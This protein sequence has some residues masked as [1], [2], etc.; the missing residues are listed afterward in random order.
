[1]GSKDSDELL[2]V[3]CFNLVVDCRDGSNDA[4]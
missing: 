2:S 4:G 3:S 1:M